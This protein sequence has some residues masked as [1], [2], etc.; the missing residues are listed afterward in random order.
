MQETLLIDRTCDLREN[1]VRVGAD[2]LQR[3]HHNNQNNREH[4]SVFCDVLALVPSPEVVP[5]ICH[6]FPHAWMLWPKF[7]TGN[8]RK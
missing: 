6:E 1:I 5:K 3:A 2:Q 7:N 4:D 8:A